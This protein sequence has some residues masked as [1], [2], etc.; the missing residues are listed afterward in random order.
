VKKL[1]A[2]EGFYRVRAGDYRIV[3]T[4]DDATSTVVVV[5]IA[6]RSEVYE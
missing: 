2:E 4:I 1:K 5:K 3:Y 6:H